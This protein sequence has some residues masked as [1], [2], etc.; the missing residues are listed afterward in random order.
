[1]SRW[2]QYD[3]P[4]KAWGFFD[5]PQL[6]FAFADVIIWIGLLFLCWGVGNFLWK[7]PFWRVAELEVV[8]PLR[9]VQAQ[10]LARVL[11]QTLKGNFLSMNLNHMRQQLLTMPWVKEIKIVRNFPN[12]LSIEIEEQEALAEWGNYEHHQKA[13][14]NKEGEVFYAP[15]HYSFPQNLP[16]FFGPEDSSFELLKKYQ[17]FSKILDKIEQKITQIYLSPRL[18]WEMRLQNGML[19]KVGR[20]SKKIKSEENL[21]RFV[22]FYPQLQ[23]DFLHLENT[24]KIIDLRY[25]WGLSWQ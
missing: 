15:L 10:D 18:S 14:V 17:N 11:P 8:T 25:L 16:Q 4:K 9:Y 24:P 1:M 5:N 6:M 3:E 7:M 2:Q 22:K 19:L 23:N 12:R 20:D 13:F 21:N